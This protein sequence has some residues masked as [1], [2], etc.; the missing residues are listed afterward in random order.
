MNM[1][2]AERWTQ[3]T[4]GKDVWVRSEITDQRQQF[5][6]DM[7]ARQLSVTN[8]QITRQQ[9]LEWSQQQR[10]R[11]QN[12]GGFGR[13]GGP[14]GGAPRGGPTGGLPMGRGQAPA[15]GPRDA[16][17]FDLDAAAEVRFRRLDTNGDGLLNYDEMPEDLRAER[18]RWDT[19][20]DGAIDL[21]EFKEYVKTRAAQRRAEN[22]RGNSPGSPNTGD[23][24]GVQPI[25]IPEAPTP[26]EEDE[27]KQVVYRRGKLP[28]EAESFFR[29]HDKDGDGQI[30]LYEW[31]NSGQPLETFFAMDRNG[32]GFV[33]VEEYLRFIG[34]SKKEPIA[35]SEP[36]SPSSGTMIVNPSA[37][38]SPTSP[39]NGP[40]FGAPGRRGPG[41]G[42]G[43]PGGGRPNFGGGRRG[44]NGP[45]GGPGG[46]R[47]NFGGGRRGGNGPPGGPGGGPPNFRGGRPGGEG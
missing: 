20:K 24:G 22:G 45:P 13:G 14:R 43:A 42:P 25:V 40:G 10:A 26:T 46:G 21:A 8:Q 29:Q 6:F 31:K 18:D 12:G 36:A 19:N 3:M 35:A 37:G 34:V 47:P 33:T 32:D 16:G 44:G 30:G 5:F 2:P 28:K 41:G 11:F 15:A 39:G 4:G 27:P 7:M 9:F 1:D 17:G 38:G 23:G